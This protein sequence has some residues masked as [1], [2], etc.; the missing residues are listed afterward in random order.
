MNEC[1]SYP[2]ICKSEAFLRFVGVKNEHISSTTY[3]IPDDGDDEDI[4]NTI[5]LHAAALDL[6][7]IEIYINNEQPT[8]NYPNFKQEL[9]QPLS[10]AISSKEHRLVISTTNID[11][12]LIHQEFDMWVKKEYGKYTLSTDQLAILIDAL[13]TAYCKAKLCMIFATRL[14]DLEDY[15]DKIINT[16]LNDAKQKLYFAKIFKLALQLKP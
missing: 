11:K 1:L 14:C 10:D 3:G 6:P 4:N 13:S 8:E 7:D 12:P 2:N 5:Q 15:E 9:L 16:Q